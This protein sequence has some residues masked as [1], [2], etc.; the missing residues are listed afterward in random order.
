MSVIDMH[1]DQGSSR[2]LFQS[3][4]VIGWLVTEYICYSFHAQT[5]KQVI[6]LLLYLPV[7]KPCNIIQK[8]IIERIGQQRLKCGKD[9]KIDDV[10]KPPVQLDISWR[11]E[12]GN[13]KAKIGWGRGLCDV[14][15]QIMFKKFGEC[16]NQAKVAL[17]SCHVLSTW[18]RYGWNVS[19]ASTF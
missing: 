13:S 11:I 2:H 17:I 6:V 10:G 1:Y 9:K 12:D 19:F 16:K 18:S 8:W 5:E 4:L 14:M 7:I 3:L 15:V